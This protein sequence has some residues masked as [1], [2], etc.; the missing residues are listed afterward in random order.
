VRRIL[1][2]V[3][4]AAMVVMMTA[5]VAVATHGGLT[6]LEAFCRAQPGGGPL[7]SAD[8]PGGPVCTYIKTTAVDPAKHGFT[9]TTTQL[10]TLNVAQFQLHEEAT[11][12]E[13][14]APT[15]TCQNPGGKDVSIDNN[16]NC[17][18]A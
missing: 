12:V 13:G 3:A 15:V 9:L 1:L 17:K 6:E 8:G 10:V 7:T 11:P 18:S 2:L 16:P 4:S 5:S 14:V